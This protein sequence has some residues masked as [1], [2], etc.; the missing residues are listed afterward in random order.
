MSEAPLY[1]RSLGRGE[2]IIAR[3][4]CRVELCE[5]RARSCRKY[6]GHV[7]DCRLRSY[8]GLSSGMP[9]AFLEWRV[10]H[11]APTYRGTHPLR[12]FFCP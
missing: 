7:K 12:N 2:A 4:P 11:Y 5:G 10:A 6:G 8:I 1:R 3:S 9:H